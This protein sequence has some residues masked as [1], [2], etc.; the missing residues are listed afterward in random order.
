MDIFVPD[1]KY[2]F[3]IDPSITSFNGYSE[4]KGYSN[5]SISFNNGVNTIWYHNVGRTIYL[6]SDL[7]ISANEKLIL[8]NV[9]MKVNKTNS[10]IDVGYGGSLS[11]I[12]NSTITNTDNC[13]NYSLVFENGSIGNVLDSI[14]ENVNDQKGIEICSSSV[15][16]DNCIIRKNQNQGIY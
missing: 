5:G 6:E 14:I 7:S 12:S 10:K 2:P 9:I 11:I 3:I 15:T 4:Y 13:N 1:M 16:I 8:N